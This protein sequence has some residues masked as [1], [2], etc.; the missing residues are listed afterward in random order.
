MANKNSAIENIINGQLKQGFSELLEVFETDGSDEELIE[1]LREVFLE[2]NLEQIHQIFLKNTDFLKEYPYIFTRNYALPEQNRYI[3]FPLDEKLYYCYD[4]QEK[5]LFSMEVNS[6]RETKYFFND[7]DKPLFVENEFNEFNL[8]F[9]EDNVRDSCDFAGD[10]HIYLW[11][12]NADLF[13]LLLYYCDLTTLLGKK[14]F[15]FLIGEER[16]K[17]PIDFKSE[18]G[19]DY[20]GMTP[21]EIR[22]EEVKRFCFW[23]KHAHSGTVFSLGV[24]GTESYIQA[25]TG[26]DF[27]TYSTVNGK[28]LYF[29]EEFKA[30]MSDPQYV[31]TYEKLLQI[32]ES[33]K[34][35]IAVDDMKDYLQWLKTHYAS[36]N[37]YTVKE[38]FCGYFLFHYEKRKLNPRIV[39]MPLFDPHMWDPSVYNNIVLSFPYYTVLTCVRE[40]IRRFGSSYIV[41]L[42]GWNKFQ[43]QYLLG[44]D[45]CNTQFLHPSMFSKYYGYR[46]EDLK[47]K[48]EIMCKVICKHLNVPY[49]DC[50]LKAEA[51]MK[52]NATNEVIKGF[53]QKAL[54]RDISGILSEFDQLRLKIFYDPILRYYGYPTFPFEEHPLSEDIV[55]KLFSYPFRFEYINFKHYRNAP[56]NVLHEWIQEV[57]QK[58]WNN[59]FVSPQLILPTE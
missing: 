52:N 34:F 3:L 9:L 19:I 16:D 1:K 58:C 54:H 28:P 10:N 18:F 22:I 7:L 40:P 4:K 11:F 21:Q 12:E 53:D 49:E 2:P 27:H 31:F 41:G 8:K 38:L 47:T 15:V 37:G 13:S 42:V 24:L 44:M 25:M 45:Y 43:T 30:I 26:Y 57:L 17:Y 20:S 39:P 56:P 23:Y 50:M 14:K 51:P 32:T 33:R 35:H 29:D 55:K 48:P 5:K 46:F 59:N 36:Q 6:D